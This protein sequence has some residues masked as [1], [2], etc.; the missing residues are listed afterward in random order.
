MIGGS[1]CHA[2]AKTPTAAEETAAEPLTPAPPDI[3]TSGENSIAAESRKAG[4]GPD[5]RELMTVT[6]G[7]SN[8]DPK[9]RQLGSFKYRQVQIRFDRDRDDKYKL[10]LKEAAWK[11]RTQEE[12]IWIKQIPKDS[13]WQPAADA[14]RLFKQIANEIRA[15]KGLGAVMSVA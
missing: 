3:P 4:F 2:H 14:E 5:P 15:D 9:M 13:G 6:L 12:G 10:M 7:P 8:A 1:P 11:G